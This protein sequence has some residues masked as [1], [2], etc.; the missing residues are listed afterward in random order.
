MKEQIDNCPEGGDGV[1]VTIKPPYLLPNEYSRCNFVQ[2]PA[3][4]C[5]RLQSYLYGIKNNQTM[6]VS[7]FSEG[8]TIVDKEDCNYYI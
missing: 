1:V 7:D 5:F 4:D 8:Q 3:N 6:S 2:C